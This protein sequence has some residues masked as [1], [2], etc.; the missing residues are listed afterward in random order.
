MKGNRGVLK[1]GAVRLRRHPKLIWCWFGLNALLA[2][3]G[4]IPVALGVGK[5]ANHSLYSNSVYH[6]VG[7]MAFLELAGNPEVR[8]WS[9]LPE[10]FLFGLVFLGGALFLNGGILETYRVDR[11]V[12]SGE[13]FQACGTFFWR[14]VRLLIF[15][16]VVLAPILMLAGGISKWSSRLASDASPEKLGFWFEIA[17]ALVIWFLMMSVRLWFDIAQVRAVAERERSMLRSTIQSL[18]LVL[19]NFGSLFWLYFR[20]SLVGWLGLTAGVWMWLKVP[21]ELVGLS[22]LLWEL[23]LF[24]WTATRLWQKAAETAWDQGQARAFCDE[25][26]PPSPAFASQP[27]NLPAV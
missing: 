9:N 15:L 12:G 10:S 21:P 27:C 24:W 22:L 2:L 16:L 23:V 17:G 14:W 3:L 26:V 1:D 20:T 11:R 13:F 19:A 25:A 4:T 6:G 7:L 8:L 18:R 5:I